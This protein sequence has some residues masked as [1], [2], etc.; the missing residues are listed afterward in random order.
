M[1]KFIAI[2][3]L[4]TT[5]AGCT[6]SSAVAVTRVEKASTAVVNQTTEQFLWKNSVVNLTLLAKE[7]TRRQ[8]LSEM[9][10]N[11]RKV[12]LR[13][14]K[15]AGKTMYVFSGSTPSGWDCSGLVKWTYGQLGI[16][17]EHRAS[18]QAN[19]GTKVKHP[20]VGDIVAFYY[21]GHK[22]AYHVGIYIG[23]GMMIDAP[24]PGKSTTIEPVN[25]H[26]LAG[27]TIRYVRIV[28][29]N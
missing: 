8:Q 19:S 26:R 25:N 15:T 2:T 29:T 14:K 5:L 18:V 24:K 22:R 3:A 23:D 1:K 21:P 16:Q 11:L 7:N 9:T 13:L 4:L 6:A 17:L 27:S 12:V 10:T 28:E 20:K